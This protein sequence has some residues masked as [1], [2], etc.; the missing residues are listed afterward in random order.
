MNEL[1][2][3]VAERGEPWVLVGTPE[4]RRLHGR[5]RGRCILKKWDCGGHGLILSGSGKGQV[6]GACECANE[7]SGSIKCEVF[8][9]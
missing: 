3:W 7:P 6:V 8:P 1:H 2:G 9:D 4:G 5:P